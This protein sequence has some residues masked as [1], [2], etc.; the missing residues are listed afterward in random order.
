M[1]LISRLV[2]I[3]LFFVVGIA[4]LAAQSDPEW[5]RPPWDGVSR[6]T[7][8]VA[9]LDRRPNEHASL[10]YRTDAIMLVNIDMTAQTI[11]ILSIPRDIHF[12]MPDSGEL[13][14]IN[15]L[16]LRGESRQEGY[17]PIFM[18]DT[19][20]YNLGIYV[21]T[22]V[23]FDFE[24]FT[25]LID[26]VGG[27]EIDL[28][29]NIYD[30]TFPNMNYGFDPFILQAGQHL[31][32]GEDALKFART[33]HGDNDYVRGQRQLQV[34]MGLRDKLLS[35]DLLTR[36][37]PQA[38]TLLQRLNDHVYTDIALDE[39]LRLGQSALA[40][41]PENLVTGALNQEYTLTY[42]SG[43]G[44]TIR[45]PDREKLITLMVSVFGENY[46]Q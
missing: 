14:P 40:I 43:R 38:P 6:F 35:P 32:D 3:C 7:V 2:F 29:Y 39:A 19:I 26:A 42:S 12:A 46:S 28:T 1:R 27:V 8:L 9:G 17:G 10:E 45:V 22:Y 23:F 41:P 13:V 36:L 16:L 20:Q 24:A 11:G 34:L 37:L 30:Q 5:V 33:R 44:N 25:T 31:L 4:P 18:M 21:D 15:T